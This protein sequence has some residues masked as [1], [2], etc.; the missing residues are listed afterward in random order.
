MNL[1]STRLNYNEEDYVYK[2]SVEGNSPK[3]GSPKIFKTSLPF[4]YIPCI[5]DSLEKDRILYLTNVEKSGGIRWKK[6]FK[7]VV[8][9]KEKI[10][11]TSVIHLD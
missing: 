5:L 11:H 1:N 4:H 10:E 6:I 8:T 7:I 3:E 9:R 2:I